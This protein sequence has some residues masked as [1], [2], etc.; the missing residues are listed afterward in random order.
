M[1][2]FP[3]RAEILPGI[4]CFTL[5][6]AVDILYP[7]HATPPISLSLDPPNMS[8]INHNYSPAPS[9]TRC[10]LPLQRVITGFSLRPPPPGR[11]ISSFPVPSSIHCHLPLQLAATNFSPPHPHPGLLPLPLFL[12]VPSPSHPNITSASSPSIFSSPLSHVSPHSNTRSP[13]RASTVRTD[14]HTYKHSRKTDG[15]TNQADFVF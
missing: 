13:C 6:L 8:T 5:D 10:P 1:V 11:L 3:A 4:L 2:I 7:S 9:S 12:P 14:T 15:R